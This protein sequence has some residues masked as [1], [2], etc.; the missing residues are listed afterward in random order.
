M[1]RLV[2]LWLLITLGFSWIICCECMGL[3]EP[4][5]SMEDYYYP[6]F[7]S[8][9]RV[10]LFT[11]PAISATGAGIWLLAR[12]QTPRRLLDKDQMARVAAWGC[13]LFV[14]HGIVRL[15]SVPGGENFDWPKPG[16][17]I[18]LAKHG[19]LAISPMIT[20]FGYW[21][22]GALL[23]AQLSFRACFD[24]RE[25]ASVASVS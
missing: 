5:K 6:L 7:E 2:A 21:G 11:A 17:S 1:R 8:L 23:L 14:V 10:W 9:M 13:A 4:L 12:F 22:F 24:K 20:V 25:Q 18:W 19:G 3:D 15:L 16:Y